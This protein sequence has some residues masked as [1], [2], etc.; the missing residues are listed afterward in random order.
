MLNTILVI[1]YIVPATA[2]MATL[3]IILACFSKTGNAPHR[4]ARLWARS[5]LLVARIKVQVKGLEHIDPRR[6][7]IFMANHQSN[8]DI[9]VL[10]GHLDVQF[11]WLAKAELFKIP[12][13]GRGMRGCGYISIDRS[14]RRAAIESIRQAAQTIRNGTSVLIF[15]EGTRSYDG[16]IQEFKKGGFYL[17]RK[18]GVPIVPVIIRGTWAVMPR[19]SLRI[20][21]G[22]VAIEVKAPIETSRFE[23]RAKNALMAH[24]HRVISDAFH[25]HGDNGA[26]C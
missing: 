19:N 21:P 2:V 6:S 9:P 23:G 11:R 13:F 4:V 8:F 3:T 18:S 10:L 26:S 24:V 5:I 20:R 15:P 25:G 12:I 14:D 17:A 7:Y 22:R 1:L 16:R